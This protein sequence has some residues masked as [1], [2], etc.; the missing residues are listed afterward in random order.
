[1][2][3]TGKTERARLLTTGEIAEMCGISQQTVIRQIDR[4]FLKGFTIPGSTHR[5][6]SV[7]SLREWMHQAGMDMESFDGIFGLDKS[8]PDEQVSGVREA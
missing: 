8:E 7:Q 4:G 2:G 5:R 6:V 3:T 1:M